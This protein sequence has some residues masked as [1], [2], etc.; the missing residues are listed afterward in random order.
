[1]TPEQL[2]ALRDSLPAWGEESANAPH[3]QAYLDFYSLQFD[4]PPGVSHQIGTVASGQ[5][6]LAAQLWRHPDAVATVLL[7]HGYFDH[8]GLYDKLVAFG[9]SRACNV[10]M[11]DLPGHGLSTGE[12]AVI[13][14][15]AHYSRAIQ[16]VLPCAPVSQAPLWVMAQSTGCAGLMDFARQHDWPFAAAVFLAP[17]VQP[18]AWWRIR[19]GHLL[20]GKFLDG[21]ARRFSRNSSDLAFL[22]FVRKDP[23]QSREVS[24]RWI[25]ALHRWLSALQRDD[26]GVGPLLIVQGDADRT[27]RWRYNLAVVQQLFPESRVE[28]IAGAGHQLANESA[29]IRAQYLGVVQDYLRSQGIDLPRARESGEADG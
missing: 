28:L 26:L 9:L 10:L 15:F 5:Y 22:E 6:R 16:D 3:L 27:V 12:A 29:T 13:D 21:L 17:L 14:D 2:Q 19:L 20:L 7:I 18:R 1:L 11:F 23:L 24:M 8:T 25:A 4:S